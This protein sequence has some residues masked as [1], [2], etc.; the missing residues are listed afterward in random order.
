MNN[1]FKTTFST[2]I[3][4]SVA[5]FTSGTYASGGGNFYAPAVDADYDV[6][7]KVFYERVTC[8]SCPH[9]DL[10]LNSTS[11]AAILPDLQRKGSIG[12]Q[13]T[14]HERKSVKWFVERQFNL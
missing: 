12:K 13:L 4:V 6:G 5:A 1:L 14:M 7:K 3:L 2:A 9:S 11:V 10:E 8:E